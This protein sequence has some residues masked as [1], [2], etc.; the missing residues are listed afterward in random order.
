M[1]KSSL[2]GLDISEGP[3]WSR[4]P[5]EVMLLSVVDAAAQAMKKQEIHVD[6]WQS[7]MLTD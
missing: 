7:V 4:K 3:P 6:I 5:R 1:R 2:S